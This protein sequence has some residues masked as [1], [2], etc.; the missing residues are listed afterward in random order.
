V[1]RNVAGN[2]TLD[3]A[4]SLFPTNADSIAISDIDNDGLAD[5]VVNNPSSGITFLTMFSGRT[6]SACGYSVSPTSVVLPQSIQA[7]ASLSVSARA[8]CSWTSSREGDWITITSGTTGN[9][10]GQVSYTVSANT[11]LVR[12]GQIVA[13]GRSIPVT[14]PGSLSPLAF[15]QGTL[16]DPGAPA[17]ALA[18]GDFNRDGIR[19]P[20]VRSK[21]EM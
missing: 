1:F 21:W 7:T 6:P 11:G 13:A 18:A 10:N 8:G 9:G 5:V 4:D 12:T 17:T 14:Q 3:R 2:G 19:G 16:I 15:S 20:L